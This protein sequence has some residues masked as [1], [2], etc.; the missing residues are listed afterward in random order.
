VCVCVCVCVCVW[1]W[2]YMGSE[3]GNIYMDVG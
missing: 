3:V 1:M 2:S